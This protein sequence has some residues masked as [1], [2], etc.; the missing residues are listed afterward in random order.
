MF[1]GSVEDNVEHGWSEERRARKSVDDRFKLITWQL[2]S[3]VQDV[4]CMLIEKL[5]FCYCMCSSLFVWT[6]TFI[7]QCL[8]FF[9][10]LCCIVL[11][12]SVCTAFVFSLG[13]FI[14]TDKLA[15]V[16]GVVLF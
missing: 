14:G 12:F 5:L 10:R 1:S 7:L 4:H 6:Q 15:L 13:M 16:S 9:L 8:C 11:L 2:V 3:F